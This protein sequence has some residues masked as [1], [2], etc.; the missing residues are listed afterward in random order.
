MERMIKAYEQFNKLSAAG[1][2]AVI[3]S[4]PAEDR[5]A[6]SEAMAYMRLFLDAEYKAAVMDQ[7]AKEIYAAARA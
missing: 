3:N 5:A 2:D 1:K 6:F 4:L 7:M